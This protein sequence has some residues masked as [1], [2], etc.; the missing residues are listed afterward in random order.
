[1]QIC[2]GSKYRDMIFHILSMI[3]CICHFRIKH[4]NYDD[5]TAIVTFS[6]ELLVFFGGFRAAGTSR[7]NI[8][9]RRL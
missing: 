8:P 3:S 1:M 2:M 4:G 5:L 9:V 6:I 7:I